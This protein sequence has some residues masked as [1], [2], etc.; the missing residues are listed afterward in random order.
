VDNLIGCRENVI[1]ASWSTSSEVILN[2]ICSFPAEEETSSY[3]E[4]FAV[5]LFKK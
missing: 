4:K 1:G 5:I 3:F 2:V